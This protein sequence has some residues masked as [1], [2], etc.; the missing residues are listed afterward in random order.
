MKK[1]RFILTLAFAMIIASSC[2]SSSTT[3]TE[4][5]ISDEA[6]LDSVQRRTFNYFW[7]GA[8]P[9]SGMARERYNVDGK[10]PQ[11]DMNIV[12]SG[13]SGFG[14]MAILSG[15]DR[16]YI[17]RKE[18]LD[19]MIRIVDFL[20][21]ADSFHGAFPHWWNGETGKVKPFSKKDDGGDLV[22][23]AFLI[24][25]LLAVHQYYINGNAEEQ[26]VAK[27]I[28]QIWKSV[29]WD[30][31]RNKQD[32]LYWHWSSQYNWDM[33]F[34]VRGYNECLIMYILAASSPTHSIPAEVYNNGWA[35]KGAIKA[36]HEVQGY[37]LNMHY[38]VQPVGPLF[39]AHYSFLGLDPN[40]LKDKCANYFEEMKNYTLINRAYC[41]RNPKGY[42]GYAEDC[43]GLTAS[44]S[45]RGYAAHSP[46]EGRDH[47]VISPTAAL[48]SI[49]YTPEESMQV[50]RNLY[51]KSDTLMGKYG[52]YDAF[53]ETEDWYPKAYLAIDQGPIAVMIENY[54]S[55]LL[56]RLFMSHPDV[57]NGLKKLGFE[58]KQVRAQ[59][60]DDNFY[61]VLP[62]KKEVFP[63]PLKA[64]EK[65]GFTWR[66]IKGWDWT[67][68]QTLEEIPY[69]KNCNMNFYM[70]CYFSLFDFP[71]GDNQW[72]LPLPD[73]L[74]TQ[75]EEIVSTC[76]A[77]D[78][79]FCFAMNPN[80]NSSRRINYDSEA[81]FK[82][83]YQHY[84]WM[85]KFG[86]N[87]FCVS[88]DD[89]TE[90]IDGIGQ[91]KV[92]NR[93]YA[94]LK[95]I[96]PKAQMIFC[97]TIYASAWLSHTPK[98]PQYLR[99]V[100]K[101]L[102][103][104]VYCFWTGDD[105]RGPISIDKAIEFKALIGHRIFIW[106]NYPVNNGV[107]LLNLGPVVHRDPNLN[108]VCDGYMS[109][110][111]RFEN[112]SNRIPTYTIADY[113]WSPKAY[114][115]NRSIGQAILHLTKNKEEATLLQDL[116]NVYYGQLLAPN[117]HANTA[118]I[119]FNQLKNQNQNAVP[120]QLFVERMEDILYRFETI[121]PKNYQA[122]K[123]V[124]RNDIKWMKSELNLDYPKLQIENLK[125]DEKTY[126]DII[127]F[128]FASLFSSHGANSLLCFSEKRHAAY[129]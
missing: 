74:K 34:G 37:K 101:E 118:R 42:K 7:D 82:D 35:Q 38:Q 117:R 11:N 103:S 85:A 13:G 67:A 70:N 107:S 83:L 4:N 58:Y 32:I 115:P 102:H 39:W 49:V 43:W 122:E 121:Y 2:K 79:E 50:M 90:G 15:I 89:I 100:A 69:L 78:I 76:K 21:K 104:E 105:V 51:H 80:L 40:G 19:R 124:L 128:H 109:N 52:F 91:S 60:I 24:Q 72:W 111:M 129:G 54:R 59:N 116:T 114:D 108:S 63:E 86:V 9:I 45:P 6:M 120:V 64:G 77:N 99:D 123:N 71:N 53:S 36:P 20:E 92:V 28:D 110:A 125:N 25:G 44:Y 106:D 30:W 17:T 46:V 112:E 5:V 8:E 68:K 75:Y 127:V 55:Q 61:V 10:Y 95:K 93:L 27:R 87:W 113:T 3:T 88:L 16:G 47:G 94:Q 23:T 119:T 97:P 48:S 33:N 84:E 81:D 14:I 73:T 22:E 96:N 56:W 126:L 18:G 65:P 1:I 57:K 12:T 66:G 98:N 26:L 62:E 41:I 29:E 31:Y